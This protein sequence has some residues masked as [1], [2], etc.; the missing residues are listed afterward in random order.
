ME[1]KS[2]FQAIV[3]FALMKSTFAG[4]VADPMITAAPLVRRDNPSDPYFIG[5]YSNFQMASCKPSRISED[6]S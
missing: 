4:P 2:L 1:L 3:A 6:R 5:Y